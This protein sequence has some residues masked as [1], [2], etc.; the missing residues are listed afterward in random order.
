MSPRANGEGLDPACETEMYLIGM[1]E[2]AWGPASF[3]PVMMVDG[4]VQCKFIR[5]SFILDWQLFV[6]Y[7]SMAESF[8]CYSNINASCIMILDI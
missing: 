3:N 1:D 7:D 4:S 2:C 8:C 5:L 6:P